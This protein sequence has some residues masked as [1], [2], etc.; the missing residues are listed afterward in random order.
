MFA[1][2]KYNF[3][4]DICDI[5]DKIQPLPK[6]NRL[7]NLPRVRNMPSLRSGKPVANQ[8]IITTAEY[9]IFQSYMTIIAVRTYPGVVLDTGWS[10]YSVTTGKY[11]NQFLGET[12]K[13]TRK[14][15]AKGIYTLQ[16]LN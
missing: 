15:I 5:C 2:L 11:R 13:E 1:R 4:L 12:A 16:D 8:F 14:K 7:M 10:S 9:T 3:I 6:G